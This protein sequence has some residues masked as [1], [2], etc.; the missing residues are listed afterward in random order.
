LLNRNE[1]NYEEILLEGKRS[2]NPQNIYTMANGCPYAEF[3][4]DHHR[5]KIKFGM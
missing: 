2:P 4:C 1:K 5:L 3:F